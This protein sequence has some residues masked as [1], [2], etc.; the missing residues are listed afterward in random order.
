MQQNLFTQKNSIIA[1]VTILFLLG[2]G[3]YWYS[4]SS[5]ASS[6]KASTDIDKSVLNKNV[7]DFYVYKEKIKLSDKAFMQKEV[8]QQLEDYTEEFPFLPP[9]GRKNP[10]VPYVAP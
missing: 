5:S 4:M 10:F 2:G 1:V 8:Y 3:Y 9:P 6:K 7:A